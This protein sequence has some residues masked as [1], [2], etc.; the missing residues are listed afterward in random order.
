MADVDQLGWIDRAV[1]AI[2][3]P[4]LHGLIREQVEIPSP[5]GAERA[6]AEAMVAS[7]RARGIDAQYQAIDADRGNCVGRLPGAGGGMDLLL[8]GHFDTSFTGDLREDFP[9]LGH[10]PRPDL[11]P[12]LRKD[13]D[14]WTG[15][16]LSNPKGGM[17]CAVA[18]ADA[19]RRARVPLRGDVI[20]GFVA[21]G[22]HQR[23]IEQITIFG[24][25][26]R[27]GSGVV[28]GENIVPFPTRSGIFVA[29]AH[30]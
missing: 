21:G 6:C 18:A 24:F 3:T 1:A 10:E 27:V 5:T 17:A 28:V 12:V 9:V 4:F 2:D 14:L 7:L 19:V 30:V 22:I 29:Q 26:Y 16:G 11:Q 15:L 8:Y 23:P 20:L 25:Y 13:G